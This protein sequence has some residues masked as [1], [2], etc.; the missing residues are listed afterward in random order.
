MG[1]LGWEF[2]VFDT[3]IEGYFKKITHNGKWLLVQPVKTRLE[4][5]TKS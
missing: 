3:T 4:P 1:V 2:Y 5:N